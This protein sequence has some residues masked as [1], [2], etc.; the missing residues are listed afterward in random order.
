MYVSAS[1]PVRLYVYV[2]IC[3]AASASAFVYVFV[4][5]ENDCMCV[6]LSLSLSLHAPI[7]VRVLVGCLRVDQCYSRC[8][9]L[10]GW[11]LCVDAVCARGGG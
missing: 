4:Y 2:C 9:C 1:V 8:V 10:R 5:D 7:F 11:P 3:S 6:R